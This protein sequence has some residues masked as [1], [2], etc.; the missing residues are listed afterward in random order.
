MKAAVSFY[1]LMKCRGLSERTALIAYL[2]DRDVQ[3][4]FHYIPLHSAPAGRKFGRFAGDDVYTTAESERIV[5]LPMYYGLAEEDQDRVIEAVRAFFAS[6]LTS[7]R[8]E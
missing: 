7:K 1:F 4:T 2:R 3:S 6:S 5:R 8:K